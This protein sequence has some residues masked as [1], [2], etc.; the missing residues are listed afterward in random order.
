M[1]ITSIQLITDSS[2][3]TRN[4]EIQRLD[5]KEPCTL[6]TTSAEGAEE[7]PVAEIGGHIEWQRAI[8]RSR[9]RR[10]F[11]GREKNVMEDPLGFKNQREGKRE[12]EKN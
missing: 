7:I 2:D 1:P 6:F 12:Q 3:M 10:P 8:M 5:E 11:K 9:D 4:Q